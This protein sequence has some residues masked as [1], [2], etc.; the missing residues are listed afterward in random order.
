MTRLHEEFV[1]LAVQ[2]LGAI[3]KTVLDLGDVPTL[4]DQL[5]LFVTLVENWRDWSEVKTA[6]GKLIVE[7]AL[8]QAGA[9][10]F[11]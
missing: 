9:G 7:E 4:R 6:D 5:D 8:E 10:F 2:D 1:A 3:A 11:R